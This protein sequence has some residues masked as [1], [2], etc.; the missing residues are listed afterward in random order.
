MR[1]ISGSSTAFP[2]CTLNAETVS[3]RLR[4]SS[5][6]TIY[7]PG[8][9][10]YAPPELGPRGK[11][12]NADAC[13]DLPRNPFT[14]FARWCLRV[15]TSTFHPGLGTFD[16][17]GFVACYLNETLLFSQSGMTIPI[18]AAGATIFFAYGAV[19]DMGKFWLIRASVPP[20]TDANGDFVGSPANVVFFD[21][22]ASGIDPVQWPFN[23]GVTALANCGPLNGPG[24]S[25]LNTDP[26]TSWWN[27]DRMHTANLQSTEDV[28]P[29][30]PPG[31]TVGTWSKAWRE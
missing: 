19:A 30:P 23:N 27:G 8:T 9:N 29:D 10:P 12:T 28:P 18:D 13:A 3:V 11:M 26:A 31:V 20:P 1:S 5:G 22:F 24:V 15:R 7:S 25:G 17:D 4:N 14:N 16:A 6:V 21:N 2:V